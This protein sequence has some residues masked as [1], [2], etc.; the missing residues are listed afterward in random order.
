MKCGIIG[1]PL[2]NPRS[3]VIWNDYF[4][5]KNIKAIMK[6]YEVNPNQFDT[7]IKKIKKDK[8]YYAFAITMPYKISVIKYCD[9]LD[10]SAELAKTVNLI[11]KNKKTS[12]I[13]GFNTDVIG[14]YKSISKNID[15]YKVITIIGL[16]GVGTCIHNYLSY[17]LP[18]INFNLITQKNIKTS[19]KNKIYKKLS[20]NILKKKSLIINCTPLG[21]N[22]KDEFLTKSPIKENLFQQIN[23]KSFIFDVVY[24]PKKNR[25]I[26]ISSI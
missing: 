9:R 19:K 3:I 23:K 24:E 16:G 12:E 8:T 17:L 14:A 1:Y 11:V 26:K 15:E 10:K 7:F 5:K 2:N 20:S 21:S 22:L 4:S 18:K 25:T 6:S 13:V